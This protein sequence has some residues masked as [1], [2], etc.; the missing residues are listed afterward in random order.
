MRPPRQ[1][2]ALACALGLA[3]SCGGTA[4]VDGDFGDGGAA[5]DGG[6][7]TSTG[8][9]MVCSTPDPVN[10]PVPCSTGASGA[11]GV[12][13]SAVCDGVNEWRST[14]EADGCVCYLNNMVRCSCALDGPGEF[15]NGFTPSCC[16]EPFPDF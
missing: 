5:S 13:G 9:F 8:Q 16:P 7:P 4:I 14:C 15:C 6:G 12:C 11:A 2:L 10:T 3:F 1:I